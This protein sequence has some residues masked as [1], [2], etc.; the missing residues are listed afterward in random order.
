MRGFLADFRAA[1]RGRAVRSESR[2]MNRGMMAETSGRVHSLDGL[3]GVGALVVVVHHSLLVV[4][5]LALLYVA[6]AGGQIES[7]RAFSVEWWLNSTPLRVF[8]AGHEAVLVFFVLSGLVLTAPLVKHGRPGAE[9]AGYYLR[10]LCRLYLPVWAAL[11]LAVVWCLLVSRGSHVGGTWLASHPDP[12]L[13]NVS[14][15]SLLLMGTSNLDSPLWSLR[16][17]VL[18]SL[19]LPVLF[20]LLRI[21]RVNRWPEIGVLVLATLA[22]SAQ[23]SFVKLALPMAW[24]THGALQYLPIFGIGMIIAM[25]PDRVQR[26]RGRM[27]A[28]RRGS[29]G[30]WVVIAV[31]LA[32][33]PSYLGTQ[34]P[35][36]ATFALQIATVTGVTMIVLA[37][38]TSPG[39]IR[40]LDSRPMQ[41]AGSRSFSIYLV[42]EPVLVSAAILLHAVNW[43]PWIG[44]APIAGAAALLLAEGF[45]RVV[46]RP[47]ITL[48]RNLGVRVGGK[49]SQPQVEVDGAVDAQPIGIPR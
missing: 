3:R 15:D 48:S 34:P 39:V 12:S 26:L 28:I 43:S 1:S 5:A 32:V 13:H 11:V 40:V 8:W 23:I 41:L 24:M 38:L 22:A 21:V 37:A 30:A 47:A 10:R 16:W 2:P 19:L 36:G 45:Y 44:V 20:W 27:A 9:W 35:A 4:P 6:P 7:P 18:F 33:S 29:R 14:H 17:E 42:H 46:E 25:S 31:L 49:R